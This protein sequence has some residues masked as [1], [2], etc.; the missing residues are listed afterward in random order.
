METSH[1]SLTKG[2]LWMHKVDN[3]VPMP[4]IHRGNYFG[5][6]QRKYPFDTM[7]VGDS[8]AVPK[9]AAPALRSAA[10]SFTA[11]MKQ[12]VGDE[13]AY[14]FTVQRHGDEVRCWRIA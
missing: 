11:R 14:R 3:T 6:G 1:I 4:A 9:E 10:S 12:R 8:F 13:A 5:P 2:M 7:A